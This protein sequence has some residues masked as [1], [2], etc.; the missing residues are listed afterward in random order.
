MTDAKK[1]VVQIESD[2]EPLVTKF[3][4]NKHLQLEEL[5]R[6]LNAGDFEALKMNWHKMQGASRVYGFNPIAEI[7]I[8]IETA[9]VAED[10]QTIENK[11]SEMVIYLSEVRIEYI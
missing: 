5:R 10:I 3:I 9:A 4:Q 2:L 8:I 11:I 7:G 1:N 6:D